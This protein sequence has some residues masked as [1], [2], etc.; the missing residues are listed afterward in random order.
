MRNITNICRE[1]ETYFMY[2]DF[3]ESHA[4]YD[5]VW[6]NVTQPERLHVTI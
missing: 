1:I 4:V 3:C 6:K 5:I 2:N